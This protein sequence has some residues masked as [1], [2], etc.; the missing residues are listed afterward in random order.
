PEHW[1]LPVV[2]G[3]LL[4]GVV[5]GSTGANWLHAQSLS[6]TFLANI[7]FALTMFVAGSKVPVL[8]PSMRTALRTG[9]TRA[10][11][12]GV[13]SV[14]VAFVIAH[15]FNTGHTALYAVLLASSS[16]AL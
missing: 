12:V 10:V 9:A 15:G 5:F 2:L 16:P 13:V 7:G 11:G 6:F 8:D 1:H 4:A 3:E 14:P